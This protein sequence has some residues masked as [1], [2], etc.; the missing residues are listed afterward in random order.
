MEFIVL[1]IVSIIVVILILR[2]SLNSRETNPI[3]N[4]KII[5]IIIILEVFCML[6]GKYGANWQL[7]W[8]IYYPVPMLM[9]VLLPPIILKLDNKQIMI[10]LL[11]SFLSAPFIHFL[12]SFFFKWK[13]YM[14]FLEI[15]YY[16]T[17][18]N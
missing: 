6:L 9:S 18:L 17:L 7:E 1:T 5:G 2:Y 15:P 4:Y 3:N 13:A 8:W 12:F 16:K 14:P 11:L 10:Y